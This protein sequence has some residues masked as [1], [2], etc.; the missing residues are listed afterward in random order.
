MI[1]NAYNNVF[2]IT[3]AYMEEKLYN[4][5]LKS[6]KGQSENNTWKTCTTGLT[7]QNNRMSWFSTQTSANNNHQGCRNPI[8][9][10]QQNQH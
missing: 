10:V 4:Y 6:Q 7:C 5:S 1:T 2:I 3:N 8:I 9:K